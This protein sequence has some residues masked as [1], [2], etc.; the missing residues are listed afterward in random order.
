M[1]TILRIRDSY[2]EL[3]EKENSGDVEYA[4]LRNI[5]QDSYE[6]FIDQYGLLNY[7]SNRKLISN[8]SAFGFTILSS[9]ERKEGERYIQADIIT[10]TL[11]H[12]EEQF[13][14]DN[15]F[16]ALAQC[17]NENGKVNIDFIQS[18]TGLS[19]FEILTRLEGHIY[20]NPQH[21]EWE[22]VDQ[23]LSGNVVEKLEAAK[24]QVSLHP[25]NVQ[26]QRSLEAIVKVQPEKIPFELLDFNLGERWIPITFYDRF[27]TNLFELNTEINYFQ[28]LDTFK[29]NTFRHNA[30]INQEYA[31]TPK[32]GRTT[33]GTYHS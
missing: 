3:S 19:E 5:L 28:S 25:D 29:V 26:F 14:T 31:V 7:P 2:L 4:G 8:D 30:K 16:E 24:E 13:R 21:N 10:K 20:I 9:L 18:S 17:L 6:K 32:S 12:K 15:P 1:K 23:Y 33:Y 11:H 22:T 27:A